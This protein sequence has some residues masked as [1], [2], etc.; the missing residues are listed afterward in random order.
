MRTYEATFIFPVNEEQFNRGKEFVKSELQKVNSTIVKEED[1]GERELAY[2]VKKQDRG[3]Y[4]YFEAE[5]APDVI[6]SLDRALKINND[7]VKYLFVKKE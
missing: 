6:V 3:H 7:V 2:T 1:L 4:Y 5:L